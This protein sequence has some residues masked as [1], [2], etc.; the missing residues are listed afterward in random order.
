MVR[1]HASAILLA[2][3]CLCDVSGA[4]EACVDTN[5][6]SWCEH[7]AGLTRCLSNPYVY[8]DMKALG[9]IYFYIPF[10]YNFSSPVTGRPDTVALLRE[11]YA[12][13]NNDT[14]QTKPA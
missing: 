9:G 10:G 4:S 7:W 8:S 1:R 13:R 3:A 5:Q 11:W 12:S 6:E 14:G 2:A